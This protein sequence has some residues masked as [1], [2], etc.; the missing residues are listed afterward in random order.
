[1]FGDWGY[2]WGDAEGLITPGDGSEPTGV[3]SKWMAVVQRQ[4]DG[5]W[6]TYRDIY[7]SNVILRTP[8]PD[9]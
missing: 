1:V 3:S 8:V 5:S 9:E 4:P 2:M 7:N 6:K